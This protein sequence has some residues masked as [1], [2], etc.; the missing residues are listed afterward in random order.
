[1]VFHESAGNIHR[2]TDEDC[3]PAEVPCGILGIA[4]RRLDSASY[5]LIFGND[6]YVFDEELLG[7][8]C[9]M[10]REGYAD[11][12]IRVRTP[13]VAKLGRN[14]P[15]KPWREFMRSWPQNV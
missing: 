2:L 7:G 9:G 5:S 1:M 13:H 4:V 11:Y 12:L 8:W 14:V 10:D 3:S 6:W 15:E